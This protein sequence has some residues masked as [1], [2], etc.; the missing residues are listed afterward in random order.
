MTIW[1]A[2]NKKSPNNSGTYVLDY[3]YTILCRESGFKTRF[4]EDQP[5]V[6]SGIVVIAKSGS[7][8]HFNQYI[9]SDLRGFTLQTSSLQTF[10][11]NAQNCHNKINTYLLLIQFHHFPCPGTN[12]NCLHHWIN[13]MVLRLAIEDQFKLT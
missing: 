12:Q 8:V 2:N 5:F 7:S 1:Q 13:C 4:S 9:D 10:N 6:L 3:N 11:S